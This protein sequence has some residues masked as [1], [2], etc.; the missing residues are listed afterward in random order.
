[1]AE[2]DKKRAKREGRCKQEWKTSGMRANKRELMFAH[3][4][5]FGTDINVSHGAI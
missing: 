1:M 2:G 5:S 4:N 3:S